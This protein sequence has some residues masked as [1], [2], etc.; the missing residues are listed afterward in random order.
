V[1]RAVARVLGSRFRLGLFDPP[2]V[3]PWRNISMQVVGNRRH[4]AAARKAAQQSIV[5][6]HNPNRCAVCVQLSVTAKGRCG[7]WC[8]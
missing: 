7:Q 4:L 6:L 5:L 8:E 1:S 2:K 3:D